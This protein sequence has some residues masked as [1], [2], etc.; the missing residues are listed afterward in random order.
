MLETSLLSKALRSHL[1][2]TVAKHGFLLWFQGPV[3]QSACFVDKR[4]G[5][6]N[7]GTNL[8]GIGKLSESW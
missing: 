6:R 7:L 3:G 4:S 1:Q 5:S 2:L 8:G